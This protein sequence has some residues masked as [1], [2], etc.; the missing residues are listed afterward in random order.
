[1]NSKLCALILAAF[2]MVSGIGAACNVTPT[3]P[4]IAIQSPG[5]GSQF[6][7]GDNVAVQSIATDPTGISRVELAVDGAIVRSDS[8]VGGRQA[9]FPVV[10]NWTATHGTHTLAVR[11]YNSAGIVSDPMAISV[12]VS[13]SAAP[14]GIPTAPT[15]P[16]VASPAATS[17]ISTTT[18]P[19]S[20]TVQ[21]PTV[22]CTNTVSFVADVTVPPGTLL[23]S[24]QAFNKIWRVRND[25]TCA[26]DSNYQFIFVGGD[27]MAPINLIAVPNTAP[28]ATADLLVAM[29]A[30]AAPGVHTANWQLYKAGQLFGAPLS[31]SI[32]VI[33]NAL[34]P[35]CAGAPTIDLFTAS[36]GTIRPGQSTTL[37]WGKVD[38]ATS[39]TIDQGI[40]GV[41][42][43]GTWT[44]NPATTTMYTLS[45]TGCGGTVTKQVTVT[46]SSP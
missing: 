28:G 14:T 3:K 20:P 4:T 43:P 21:V 30:P 41:G 18:A 39:A 24:N 22:A 37:M 36:P 11:A 32:N 15:A 25:G 2:V 9:T 27:A 34:A 17:T 46:V 16:V 19:L 13:P 29:T 38:N 1:M 31:V 23:A 6:R 45:A 42:T 5:H 44:V 26:W 10:Q 35:G 40:G 12:S 8:P 7:H 33:S